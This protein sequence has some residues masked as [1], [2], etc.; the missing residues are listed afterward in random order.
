MHE[1]VYFVLQAV[2]LGVGV[3][4]LLANVLAGVGLN[5]EVRHEGGDDQC[6]SSLVYNIHSNVPEEL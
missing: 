6:A 1:T 3:Q 5:G 2:D 4:D